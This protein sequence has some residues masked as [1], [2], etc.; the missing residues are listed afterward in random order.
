MCSSSWSGKNMQSLDVVYALAS[1]SILYIKKDKPVF[2]FSDSVPYK[3][4]YHKDR[5]R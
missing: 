4:N 1:N 5:K 2:W 3:Y